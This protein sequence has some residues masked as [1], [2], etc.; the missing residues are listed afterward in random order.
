MKVYITNEWDTDIIPRKDFKAEM[1]HV[2]HCSAFKTRPEAVSYLK[3]RTKTRIQNK[4]NEL[5]ELKEQL[6]ELK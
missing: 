6:K 1:A 3:R 2:L 5:E 4:I